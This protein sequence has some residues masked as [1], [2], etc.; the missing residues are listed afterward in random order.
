MPDGAR[1]RARGLSGRR[2][3]G[4]SSATRTSTCAAPRSSSAPRRCWAVRPSISSP[5]SRSWRETKPA[6]IQL[7]GD[8][9]P[10]L[11]ADLDPALVG[12]SEPR[13]LNCAL[14]TPRRRAPDQL[15]DRRFPE[16]G[17]G[18][19]RL[20]RA[21]SR[22]ALGCRRRPRRASTPPTRSPPGAGTMPA[23]RRAPR[24]LNEHAF[25]AVRFRGPG[26]DL[27]VGLLPASR[28]MC[29]AFTTVDGIEH[30]PNLPT[31]EVFTS[32]DWRRTEGTVRA[33]MPLAAVGVSRPRSRAAVRGRQG[34]R[35]RG[36]RGCRARPQPARDRP[37]GGLPRRGRARR[38]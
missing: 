25:D 32:P 38:R 8:A 22:A 17:L 19:E 31:E 12:K 2:D 34:R 10:E 21:R 5:G 36:V 3:A 30:I 6:L 7:T 1:R 11:L 29:A 20:R 15:G 23:S 9:E 37:A 16:P 14:P 27:V 13:D 35:R 33:T 28:W 26:T 24:Q 4:S 18:D